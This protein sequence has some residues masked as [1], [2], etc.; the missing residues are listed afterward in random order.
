MIAIEKTHWPNKPLKVPPFYA[1]NNKH[2]MVEGK[3]PSRPSL[4]DRATA[5][6]YATAAANRYGG[7]TRRPKTSLGKQTS[8]SLSKKTTMVEQQRVKIR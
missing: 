4:K 5:N 1:S 2:A 6:P 8:P 7:K 3:A